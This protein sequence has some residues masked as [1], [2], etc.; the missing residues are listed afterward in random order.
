M[1]PQASRSVMCF[2]SSGAFQAEFLG[3]ELSCYIHYGPIHCFLLEP[4]RQAREPR[5]G[6]L[7]SLVLQLSRQGFQHPFWLLPKLVAHWPTPFEGR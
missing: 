4:L 3:L 7:F 5:V 1:Y 6:P 2:G